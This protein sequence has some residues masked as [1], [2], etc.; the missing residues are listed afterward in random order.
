MSA[1]WFDLTADP[2]SE[3]PHI[4]GFPA[5]LAAPHRLQHLA[6]QHN[7]AR[8]ARQIG[9]HFELTPRALAVMTAGARLVADGQLARTALP[10]H[11]RLWLAASGVAYDRSAREAFVR[12]HPALFGQAYEVT[13]RGFER[14]QLRHRVSDTVDG[15]AHYI[16]TRHQRWLA[17]HGLTTG[18]APCLIGSG[19]TQPCWQTEP[20]DSIAH[21]DIAAAA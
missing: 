12:A 11:L 9:Q 6:M 17:A 15:F 8:I 2:L 21:L 16:A 10:L 19:S 13:L 1:V 18:L 7:F 20:A 14:W 4:I 5:I 3:G